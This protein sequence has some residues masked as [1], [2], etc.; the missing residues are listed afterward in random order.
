[1]KEDKIQITAQPATREQRSEVRDTTIRKL[2]DLVK[3]DLNKELGSNEEVLTNLP[4]NPEEDP[5][6][7]ESGDYD[8]DGFRIPVGKIPLDGQFSTSE[9]KELV[10]LSKEEGLLRDDVD[11]RVRDKNSLC[12]HMEIVEPK[13]EAV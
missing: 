13:H 7:D 8:E 3:Q 2:K 6:S 11:V 5:E 1:M 9:L 12:E 4:K 10:E